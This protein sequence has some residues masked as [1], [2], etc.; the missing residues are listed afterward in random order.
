M[1]V[2]KAVMTQ[3][4]ATLTW[5]AMI[6]A[7]SSSGIAALT[8]AKPRLTS[9][10]IHADIEIAL[11]GFQVAYAPAQLNRNIQPHGINDAAHGRLVLRLAGKRAVQVNQVD[12]ARPLRQPMFCSGGRIF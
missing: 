12:A 8:I 3:T 2:N 1:A 11:D 6:A 4:A 10:A 9:H 7:I 5:L